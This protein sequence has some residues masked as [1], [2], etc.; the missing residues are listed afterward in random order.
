[1]HKS[2][3]QKIPNIK[4]MTPIIK[5]PHKPYGSVRIRFYYGVVINK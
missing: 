5:W 4:L 2:G 3:K 1:M